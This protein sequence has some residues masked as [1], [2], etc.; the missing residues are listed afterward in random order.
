[1]RATIERVTIFIV[2]F[3]HNNYILFFYKKI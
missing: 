1:M 2:E 3:S